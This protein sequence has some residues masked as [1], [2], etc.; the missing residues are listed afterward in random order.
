MVC[1]GSERDATVPV[2]LAVHLDE[3]EDGQPEDGEG[4]ELHRQ[5]APPDDASVLQDRRD[6]D[7]PH[8][9]R[10]RQELCEVHP[11]ISLIRHD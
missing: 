9:R 2:V 6:G 4:G 8:H 3:P 10:A 11:P 7:A 5:R 1:P